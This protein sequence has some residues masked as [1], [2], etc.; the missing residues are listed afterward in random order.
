M[1]MA[2]GVFAVSAGEAVADFLGATLLVDLMDPGLY[3]GPIQYDLNGRYLSP[4][5][6]LRQP[7]FDGVVLHCQAL[8]LDAGS[9]LVFVTSNGLEVR[10]TD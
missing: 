10:M 9:P 6:T 8:A 3:L 4:E 7:T 5:T 1:P 2:S